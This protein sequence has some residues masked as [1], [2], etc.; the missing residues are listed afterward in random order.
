MNTSHLVERIQD[1]TPSSAKTIGLMLLESGKINTQDAERVIKLQ[2]EENLRFGEAAVK[3][4]LVQDAD[5]QQMLARQF[6]YPYLSPG[7]GGFS[8]D[9][10]AAYYPFSPQVESL[11]ALRSQLMLRWFNDKRRVLTLTGANPGDGTSYLAANLGIVF[12]QLGERTLLIDANLRTPQLHTYFNLDNKAGLSDIL[13]ER[14]TLAALTRIPQFV[15]LSV[16][17]AGTQPPN[18]AELLARSNLGDLITL[19]SRHYDVILIDTPPAEQSADF[20]AVSA[21]VGGALISVRKNRTRLNEVAAIKDMLAAAG[22]EV[23]G[24][25]INTH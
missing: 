21:N 23:V 25:V 8:K 6:D 24:A 22:A 17:T 11:R 18:P 1:S 9:L 15:D 3:L 10:V 4:G 2:K 7:E 5:I 19:L 20:Q 13:A 14:A 12:S 16:L